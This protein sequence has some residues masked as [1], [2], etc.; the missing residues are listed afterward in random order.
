MK[1]ILLLVFGLMLAVSCDDGDMV[2]ESLN[3]DDVTMQKCEDKELYFKAK[4]REMLIL[5]LISPTGE[6][7]INDNLQV[8]EELEVLTNNTNQIIYRLYDNNISNQSMLCD[9]VPPAFPQVVD[10][11]V[12]ENNGS[13]LISK[14]LQVR[15]NETQPKNFSVAY[16]FSILFRNIVLSRGDQQIKYPD[17]TFGTYQAESYTLNFNQFDR[18]EINS[19]GNMEFYMETSDKV[20]QLKLSESLQPAVGEQSFQLSDGQYIKIKINQGI[21]SQIEGY[22][23]CDFGND[24]LFFDVWT[25]NEGNVK[26]TAREVDI[27]GTVQLVYDFEITQATFTNYD[28]TIQ[29]SELPIGSYVE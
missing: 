16:N 14:Q 7:L 2:F 11:Y 21:L 19:C 18:D 22:Q 28:R 15:N 5:N 17:Y 9:D 3:F 20:M 4:D 24:A 10:E 26:V 6:P 8:G 23:P 27:A 12:S 29:I 1:K 25:A 13:I